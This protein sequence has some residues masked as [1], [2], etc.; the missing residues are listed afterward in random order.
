MRRLLAHCL[1]RIARNSIR[2]ANHLNPP[3]QTWIDGSGKRWTLSGPP[4][5]AKGSVDFR[6]DT[7]VYTAAPPGPAMQRYLDELESRGWN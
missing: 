7:A 4:R 5:G 2:A 6:T 3:T 1:L